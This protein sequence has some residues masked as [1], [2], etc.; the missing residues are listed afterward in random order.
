MHGNLNN[1][2]SRS[3][4]ATFEIGSDTPESE[5]DR[6]AWFYNAAQSLLGKD[7]GFGL[8]VL[9]GYPESTCYAYVARNPEKRRPPP[10]HL[11]WKLFNRDDG[12]P[13]HDA[14]M[15]GC[16]AKWWQRRQKE[17]QLAAL[18]IHIFNQLDGV[19]E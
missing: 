2:G 11:L 7:A 15:H 17:R 6:D 3:S 8:H 10:E 19:M 5:S 18:A 14:F 13:W 12:E 16:K 4:K 9:T 1:D